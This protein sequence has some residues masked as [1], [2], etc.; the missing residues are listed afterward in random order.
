MK[1]MFNKTMVKATSV[2]LTRER[3]QVIII[4][5]IVLLLVLGAGAPSDFAGWGGA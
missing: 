2:R 5:A 4:L 1:E 3:I